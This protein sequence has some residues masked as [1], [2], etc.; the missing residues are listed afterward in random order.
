MN[1]GSLL[2]AKNYRIDRREDSNLCFSGCSD[3]AR[4]CL[5]LCITFLLVLYCRGQSLSDCPLNCANGGQCMRHN[6]G[7]EDSNT[8]YCDCEF[9]N[10]D[11][12]LIGY[13]GVYCQTPFVTCTNG[14]GDSFRC[15]NGGE[16][17]N[18]LNKKY[19]CTQEF[20]GDYCEKFVGRCDD[21]TSGYDCERY[22]SQ[23]VSGNESDDKS[24]ISGTGVFLFAF[25]VAFMA[26]AIVSISSFTVHHCDKRK[27]NA[28]STGTKGKGMEMQA[29]G[30]EP[31]ETNGEII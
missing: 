2:K 1:A 23:H 10:T 21:N 25:G 22:N 8:H 4:Y 11:S 19:R 31:V 5:R 29:A 18:S 14:M 27:Q 12:G 16:C 20:A 6:D 30:T 9:T 28:V 15:L 3:T 17:S 26:T 13:Q 7:Y 24:G